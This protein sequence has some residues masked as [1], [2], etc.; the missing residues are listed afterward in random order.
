M[1]QYLLFKFIHAVSLSF[2]H[3]YFMTVAS[4]VKISPFP[5][6]VLDDNNNR[7]LVLSF[8]QIYLPSPDII[9]IPLS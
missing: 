3:R 7:R 4:T 5:S 6:V 8:I 1:P 2:I 9:F